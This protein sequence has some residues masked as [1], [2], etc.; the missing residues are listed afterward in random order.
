MPIPC[1]AW[2]AWES[3]SGADKKRSSSKETFKQYVRH[4]EEEAGFFAEDFETINKDVPRT[5]GTHFRS[6]MCCTVC[7]IRLPL[8]NDKYNAFFK[9]KSFDQPSLRDLV[10]AAEDT[11]AGD[12]QMRR[13]L[14]AYVVRN[15][16][17]GYAQGLNFI[18][19]VLLA[20]TKDEERSFWLL[21]AFVE[22][23][24]IRDF[25][26]RPP[27]GM[28]GFAIML[29][30]F[31]RIGLELLVSAKEAIGEDMLEFY[32]E[33]LLARWAIKVLVDAVPLETMLVVWQHL[34]RIDAGASH[35]C[36]SGRYAPFIAVIALIDLGLAAKGKGATIDDIALAASKVTVAELNGSMGSLEV[37]L[38]AAGGV[39]AMDA[40]VEAEKQRL[41]AK[42]ASGR[43]LTEVEHHSHFTE[44]QL[45][46]L[47]QH[48][49][50]IK[51]ASG[52][53]SKHQ[54]VSI[55][56]TV[57]PQLPSDFASSTF[58]LFDGDDSGEADFKELVAVLSVV[59]RGTLKERL[60]LCFEAF[61][62]DHS[63]FL[64]RDEIT[65]VVNCLTKV[66]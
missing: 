50:T 36:I 30:A 46:H 4:S 62:H 52:C 39:S 9:G 13:V 25:F 8:L 18:A 43:R 20:T 16:S 26:C 44:A 38:E 61:D 41:A 23:V 27:S 28:N 11:V 49:Q 10:L 57:N 5:H 21:N 40:A 7:S 47:L 58:E 59:Q 24:M 6:T 29:A 53:I 15:H 66:H 3:S 63:G 17:P 31:K 48:F 19:K 33:L 64:E 42:W 37:Q 60:Q 32:L 55:V 12:E 45:Q 1:L 22:D 56:T 54:F 51:N 35:P 65:G 34:F 14:M 2:E